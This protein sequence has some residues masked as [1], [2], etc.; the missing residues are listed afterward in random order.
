[1]VVIGIDVQNIRGINFFFNINI[2]DFIILCAP[3]GITSPNENLTC[4]GCS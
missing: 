1:M 3:E 4:T 2:S